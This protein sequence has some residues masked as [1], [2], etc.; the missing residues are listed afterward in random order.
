[1]SVI[2]LLISGVFFTRILILR[3]GTER[4]GIWT[5]AVS[6]IEYL[7]M[8]DLGF[9]PATVK[10]SAEY[11]ALGRLM[12]LNRLINTSLGYAVSVGGVM[13]TSIWFLA[14][15]IAHTLHIEDPSAPFLIR[16]VGFSWS[17]GLVFNVFSA[18]LEGMQR[19]DLSNRISIVTTL[20][21]GGVS[22][23]AV[24]Q[25]YGL[26]E[27]GWALVGSQS[28]GYLM[29]FVACR[30]VYPGL[31]IGPSLFHWETARSVWGYANQAIPGILGARFA[32]ASFPTVIALFKPTQFVTFFSQTQRMMEYA[33]DAVSRVG[34]VTAPRISEWQ[35]LGKRQEI[36]ELARTSNR[37]CLALWGLWGSFL[38]VYGHDLCRIWIDREFADNVAPLIPYFVAGYTLFMGQ[39]ISSAVLMGLGKFRAYSLTSMAESVVCVGLMMVLLPPFGLVGAVAGIAAAI[40]V[41]RCFVLSYLF[42]QEFGISQLSYLGDIFPK[43]LG[44]MIGAG[45]LLAL[46]HSLLPTVTLWTLVAAL[47]GY[48]AVYGL[49]VYFVVVDGEQRAWIRDR[50]RTALRL[51]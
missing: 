9:R 31:R 10:M 12:E 29:M 28:L 26:R 49:G 24:T 4:F 30:S 8:I 11:F 17:A 20:L 2:A 33:A 45:A 13:L 40:A 51:G 6:L 19:F 14:D 41:N 1:M 7:W 15:W 48:A 37:Y 22:V 27:M 44:L 32:Q 46:L 25:G 23:W 5:W 42:A 43:P 39:F 21:R 36:L 38:M 3:L 50:A 47:V 34:M 18:V 16:A 35:A